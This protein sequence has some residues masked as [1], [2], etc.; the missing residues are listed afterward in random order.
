MRT[1]ARIAALLVTAFAI[2]LSFSAR[3]ETF[4]TT[5]GFAVTLPESWE[6]VPRSAL[7]EAARQIREVSRGAEISRHGVIRAADRRNSGVRPTFR[8][9]SGGRPPRAPGRRGAK[10]SLFLNRAARGRQGECQ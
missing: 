1:R 8:R 10:L 9:C 4:E 2:P 3:A 7:D 5:D 6:E